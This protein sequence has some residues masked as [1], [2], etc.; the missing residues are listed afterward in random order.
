MP[1]DRKTMAT[2][3][4]TFISLVIVLEHMPQGRQGEGN[5][6]LEE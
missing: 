1:M 6:A 2:L 4:P 3:L 5:L